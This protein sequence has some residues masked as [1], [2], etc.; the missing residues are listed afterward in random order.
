MKKR[1]WFFSLLMASNVYSESTVPDS[2]ALTSKFQFDMRDNAGELHIGSYLKSPSEIISSTSCRLSFSADGDYYNTYSS[3]LSLITDDDGVVLPYF[4]IKSLYKDEESRYWAKEIGDVIYKTGTL[5]ASQD[6]WQQDT[7]KRNHFLF[8]PTI[9]HAQLAFHQ[10]TMG[11][12]LVIDMK[13]KEAPYNVS[14]KV[15][16]L[17]A[18]YAS[19]VRKCIKLM[20]EVNEN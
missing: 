2:V 20:D 14:I 6:S 4:Q 8:A 7:V 1:T 15:E 13:Q 5:T 17:S 11:Q 3:E 12:P 16:P 18:T 10:I 9:D 19:L